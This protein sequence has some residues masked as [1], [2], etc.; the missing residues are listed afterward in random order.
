LRKS[1]PSW[2][3]VE[4]FRSD[5]AIA[6]I[7]RVPGEPSDAAAMSSPG[8]FSIRWE[9]SRKPEDQPVSQ[10]GHPSNFDIDIH[11]NASIATVVRAMSYRRCSPHPAVRE[12]LPI[13]FIRNRGGGMSWISQGLHSISWKEV[14]TYAPI[15]TASVAIIAAGFAWHSIRVQ[16][17]LARKR[18]I[19]DVFL[20]TE[21]DEKIVAAYDAYLVG[22]EFLKNVGDIDAFSK[23]DN[24]KAIRKYLNI[25][26]LIAVGM[27]QGIFSKKICYHYWG[28]MM[29]EAYEECQSVIKHAQKEHEETYCDLEKY[30]RRWKKPNWRRCWR[31]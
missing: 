22:V 26:E 18:A 5:K 19:V 7:R 14:A 27:Y 2:N 21:M 23:T 20:K 13:S 25:H 1:R 6:S 10:Y 15:V 3:A 11:P 24:Y 4:A 8:A 12:R 9:T 16:R 28:N 31:I 30:A 29:I 17:T